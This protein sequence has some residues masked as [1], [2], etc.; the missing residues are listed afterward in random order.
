MTVAWKRDEGKRVDKWTIAKRVV[1]LTPAL[2][3]DFF[4]DT[5]IRMC[6]VNIGWTV[7]VLSPHVHYWDPLFDDL[8]VK[9]LLL[10]FVVN[11][12]SV[13]TMYTDDECLS[14]SFFQE[15]DHHGIHF[16]HSLIFFLVS[17]DHCWTWFMITDTMT[18]SNDVCRVS[19]LVKAHL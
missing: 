13:D 6:H 2:S 16:F 11:G 14:L 4:D 5:Y 19:S 15:W 1:K 18:G 9:L 7:K 10:R 12:V 3:H 17:D 8:V